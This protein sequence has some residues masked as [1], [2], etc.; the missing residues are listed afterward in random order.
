MSINDFDF[1]DIFA[2]I[3]G[4]GVAVLVVLGIAFG[5]TIG[6]GFIPETGI[7]TVMA[8]LATMVGGWLVLLVLAG[9]LEW[10]WDKSY[11][12]QEA[13]WRWTKHLSTGFFLASIFIIGGIVYTKQWSSPIAT[14]LLVIPII[15]CIV[16]GFIQKL[17]KPEKDEE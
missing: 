6:A 8:F 15:L 11:N 13:V 3:V 1:G 10:T 9:T 17:F 5:L 14:P 4:Y 2:H 12:N 16:F 7:P